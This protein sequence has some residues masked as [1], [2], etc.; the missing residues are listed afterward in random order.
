[1]KKVSVVPNKINDSLTNLLPTSYS[2]GIK[3]FSIEKSKDRHFYPAEYIAPLFNAYYW[4]DEHSYIRKDSHGNFG[5][6]NHPHTVFLPKLYALIYRIVMNIP[7]IPQLVAVLKNDTDFAS[8]CCFP[9]PEKP[10]IG[11]QGLETM[12]QSLLLFETRDKLFRDALHDLSGIL[13]CE[14][15]TFKGLLPSVWVK[16]FRKHAIP[17]QTFPAHDPEFEAVFANNTGIDIIDELTLHLPSELRSDVR[18][19][20][21]LN[22]LR[23]GMVN[24][25]QDEIVEITKSVTKRYRNEA[26]QL[27]Y[28]QRSLFSK[29]FPNSNTELWETIANPDAD[30]SIIIAERQQEDELL[31]S[32]SLDKEPILQI[33]DEGDINCNHKMD[34]DI[35][36]DG[37]KTAYCIYCGRSIIYK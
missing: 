33:L 31:Q 7:N 22:C 27:K 23:L 24:L 10:F 14:K 8:A 35:N 36:D 3:S 19:E 1:M 25:T 15:L 34:Y 18:Q 20:A 5:Y 6:T 30:D 21:A 2:N 13:D 4:Q 37:K 29:P 12:Q 17:K 28:K 11:I 26:M 16:T 9:H 32:I